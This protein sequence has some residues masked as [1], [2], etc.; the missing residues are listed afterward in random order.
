MRLFIAEDSRSLGSLRLGR[1]RA[2]HPALQRVALRLAAD[3][4]GLVLGH[5]DVEALRALGSDGR[6]RRH[7]PGGE[8]VRERDVLRL[9][10]RRPA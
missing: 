1:L 6:E 7:V 9:V 2:A 5:D 3:R 4:A 10:P 8:A